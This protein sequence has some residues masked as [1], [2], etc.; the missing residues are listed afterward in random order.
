MLICA[1]N[2]RYLPAAILIFMRCI[3]YSVLKYSWQVLLAGLAYYVIGYFCYKYQLLYAM[4][5]R[6]HSTGKSWVMIC[7]RTVVGLVVFQLT[8]AGQ[9]ALRGAVRRSIVVF[10]LLVAT[11]WFSQVY[12]RSY[13]PLMNFIALRSIRR[14]EHHQDPGTSPRYEATVHHQTL[15]ESRE[16][17][18]RFINPSIIAPLEDVWILDKSARIAENSQ[19][20]SPSA[21]Q[22]EPSS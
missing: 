15:D 4:D 21:S 3:V 13:K 22:G 16:S 6:Q 12:G 5:H 8:M 20:A 9:L 11:L 14:A 2:I 17:G 10:P 1:T 19:A 7:D 18:M